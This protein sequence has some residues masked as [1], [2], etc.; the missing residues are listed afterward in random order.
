MQVIRKNFTLD[1]LE[2]KGRPAIQI[3][4]KRVSSKE[5]LPDVFKTAVRSLGGGQKFT[6]LLLSNDDLEVLHEALVKKVFHARIDVEFQTF[7]AAALDNQKGA[8]GSDFRT[9]LKVQEEANKK[10][11]KKSNHVSVD[12]SD[13][14]GSSNDF[15]ESRFSF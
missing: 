9:T 8:T 2:G 11:S 1:D 13:Y 12:S 15:D 3:A 6:E 10:K 5:E 4:I 7:K 14:L